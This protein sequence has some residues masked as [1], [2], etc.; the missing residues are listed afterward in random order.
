MHAPV[1]DLQGPR[2]T[3]SDPPMA[4]QH[5]EAEEAPETC[6][7]TPSGPTIPLPA[8]PEELLSP[9]ASPQVSEA[10][11]GIMLSSLRLLCLVQQPALEPTPILPAA[12]GQ[13]TA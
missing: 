9:A 13:M 7:V 11:G 2:A 8:T 10:H 6:P 4:E 3:Q 5:L 12:C 1:P